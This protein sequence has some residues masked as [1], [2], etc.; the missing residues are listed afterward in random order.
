[1]KYI[2]TAQFDQYLRMRKGTEEYH[3]DKSKAGR[4]GGSIS[5]LSPQQAKIN[6]TAMGLS[7]IKKPTKMYVLCLEDF[8]SFKKGKK[9]D[10]IMNQGAV[11]SY[12]TEHT[13]RNWVEFLKYFKRFKVQ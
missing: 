5:R 7:N 11:M 4:I 8:L 9:Y 3:L 6:T 12:P 1:M 2:G 10:I 13:F